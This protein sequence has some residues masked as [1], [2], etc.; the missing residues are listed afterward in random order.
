[1]WQQERVRA[2]KKHFL[3]FL[4]VRI[5][6]AC[7]INF[8]SKYYFLFQYFVH[9]YFSRYETFSQNFI[10]VCLVWNILFLSANI[11]SF[12]R[13]EYDPQAVTSKFFSF[14]RQQNIKHYM[15]FKLCITL[16]LCYSCKDADIVI[17]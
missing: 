5:K 7:F 13:R 15:I 11:F 10:A 8:S 17:E 12:K 4:C 14:D 6:V 2:K 9:E 3:Q 1:M 16:C